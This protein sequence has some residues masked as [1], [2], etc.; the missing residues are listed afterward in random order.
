M[1]DKSSELATDPKLPGVAFFLIGAPRCGTTALAQAL[2]E[3]DDVCFSVPKETHFFAQIP[4]NW[5]PDL[6]KQEFVRTF[7]PADQLQQ[8][9]AMGE[10]SVSYLYSPDA[11]RAIDTLFRQAKFLVMLRN[12]LEMLPSYHARILFMMEEEVTDFEAAW[13][14]QEA[15]AEGREIPRTCRDPRVLQYREIGRLGKHLAKLFE[16]VP[17]DRIKL[18]HFEDFAR[19]PLDVYR[20][21]IDFLG[22]ADDHRTSMPKVNGTRVYR[23]ALLH[24]LTTRPPSV[25]FSRKLVQM[26]MRKRKPL[27]LRALRYLRRSNVTGSHWSPL[28]PAMRDEIVDSLKDDVALLSSLVDRD[29]SGWFASR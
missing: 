1:F 14:L 27:L 8:R 25:E 22:L 24:R 9:A 29:L 21:V 16:I 26:K 19:A 17:R 2:R 4:E 15:R 11:I 13:H 20:D 3:R 7:F 5:K 12:P 10:G 28:S 23:S 18:I 6:L